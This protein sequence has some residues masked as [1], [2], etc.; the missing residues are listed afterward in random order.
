[1]TK[2][3]LTE[4]SKELFGRTLYRIEA[5]RDFGNVSKGELGGWLEREENLS[6]MGNARVYGDADCIVFKNSWSSGRYFTWT[7]SNDMWRVGCF[8]GTGDELV[9]KAYADSEL[10]GKCYEAYVELVAKL[11]G[12]D[13]DDFEK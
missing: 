7:K 4:E 10:S 9:K 5:T 3:K 1:M 8:Y 11:K 12:F 13:N 2:F 6:Q